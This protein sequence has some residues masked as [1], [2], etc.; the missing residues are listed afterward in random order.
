MFADDSAFPGRLHQEFLDWISSMTSCS[1]LRKQ[2]GGKP[3]HLLVPAADSDAYVSISDTT[4]AE[5]V[6]LRLGRPN[7][8]RSLSDPVSSNS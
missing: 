6:C 5:R 2:D 8:T 7:L 4:R 1:I 3:K